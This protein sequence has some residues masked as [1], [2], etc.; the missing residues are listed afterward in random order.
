LFKEGLQDSPA[1]V[2][3][4]ED[5]WHWTRESKET[6]DYLV[7]K[8]NENIS[9]LMLALEKLVGHND[10]LAYLT[11]MTVRLIELRRV[12]K[13]TGSIYLHCDSTASHYLKVVLDI[14]FGKSNFRNEIIWERGTA[15]GGKAGGDKFVPNH[16][17]LLFYIKDV[18]EF[19]YERQYI[20]YTQDYIDQRFKYTDEKGR[21]YRL[22]LDNRR[23]YLD[24]SRGKPVS[25]IWTDIFPINPMAK[26][27]LGYPTQKPEALLERIIKAS[28]KEDDWALDPFCGCGTTVAVSEKLKRRWVGIDI[29]ALAINLIKHRLHDSFG[30]GAKQIHLD[31]LPTDLT[32][33]HELFKKD[34]FEFEYWA[35]DLVNAMPAQSKSEENMRGADKGIDG[36]ITFHK[37]IAGN[38]IDYGKAI[39]QVKGGGVQRNQIATLKGDMEREKAEA[40]IFI[41]LEE[42]TKPMIKEVVDAGTFTT[43]LTGKYEFSKIQ[44]LTVEELLNGKKPDLPR[45]LVKNYY[46]RAKT[47]DIEENYSNKKLL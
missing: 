21:R 18:N 31:G 11:M 4:F 5:S 26:E 8:T 28:S 41:T 15:S 3:A 14:I 42:P 33:A 32:G 22:Q 36:I 39:V 19:Y 29:T 40:G 20:T 9:N 38:K 7:T 43:P 25:D 17:V 30:L 46:K 12:L 13:K 6:F 1:Q 34:S 45:A 27:K 16:D 24:E 44:I 35:L 37:N 47:V 23:Q 10:M 2:K